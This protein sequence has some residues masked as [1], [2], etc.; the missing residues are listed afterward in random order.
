MSSGWTDNQVCD[1]LRS[2]LTKSKN[3]CFLYSFFHRYVLQQYY[4]SVR[5]E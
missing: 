1:V 2:N 3:Q 4:F 5:M